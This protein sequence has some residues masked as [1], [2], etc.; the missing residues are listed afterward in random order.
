MVR[1][2]IQVEG[3]THGDSGKIRLR[4]V[5]LARYVRSPSRLE[6]PGASGLVLDGTRPP[7]PLGWYVYLWLAYPPSPT[8]KVRVAYSCS[9]SD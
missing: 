2:P 1:V 9:S 8:E 6:L 4:Q 5:H 7:A 3:T